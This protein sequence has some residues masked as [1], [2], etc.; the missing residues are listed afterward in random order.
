MSSNSVFTERP[1][2]TACFCRHLPMA[3][4]IDVSEVPA[5]LDSVEVAVRAVL[6]RLSIDGMFEL[7]ANALATRT[8]RAQ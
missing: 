4:K 6:E 1:K 2:L 7:C 8:G 5:V 3:L